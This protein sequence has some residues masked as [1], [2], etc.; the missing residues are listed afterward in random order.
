[1]LTGSFIVETIFAI[2]GLGQYFVTSIYNRDY[3]VIL[4]VTVFYSTLIVVLKII[5]DMI[6]PIIDPRVTTEKE[7]A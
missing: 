5:V 6:Y 1:M 2:P 3:T 7:R 4:G